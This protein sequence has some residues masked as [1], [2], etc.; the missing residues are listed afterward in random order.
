MNE[1]VTY[2]CL[3]CKRACALAY[4]PTRRGEPEPGFCMMLETG[5]VK[6]ELVRIGEVD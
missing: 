5:T 1:P 2:Q 4:T 3:G 6:W